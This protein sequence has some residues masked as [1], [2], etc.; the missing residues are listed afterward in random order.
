MFVCELKQGELGVRRGVGSAPLGKVL[1]C[2]EYELGEPSVPAVNGRKERAVA[3]SGARPKRLNP[4]A[5]VRVMQCILPD[6]QGVLD[7]HSS[8]ES[9]SD[10][11]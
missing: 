3:A 6:R 5:K 8:D 4:A 2:C 11:V 7:L 9:W 1:E 10:L